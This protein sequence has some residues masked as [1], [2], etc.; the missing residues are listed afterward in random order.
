MKKSPPRRIVNNPHKHV[1]TPPPPCRSRK[2]LIQKNT[3]NKELACGRKKAF[4]FVSVSVSIIKHTTETSIGL[5][6]VLN[7][8]GPGRAAWKLQAVSPTPSVGLLLALF[9]ALGL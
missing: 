5:Q 7:V 2:A 4:A 3:S 1:Q 9:G 6:Q 8:D